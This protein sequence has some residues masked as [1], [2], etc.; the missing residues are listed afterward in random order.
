M[1][2]GPAEPPAERRRVRERA[3]LA[4]L[5]LLTCV[6]SIV[7]SL[8]APLV[9]AVAKSYEIELASAQWILSAA[10]LSGALASPLVGRLGGRRRRVTVLVTLAIVT[11]GCL[12]SAASASLDTGFSA[13]AAGRALQGIGMAL[14]PVAIAVARDSIPDPR[15]QP[16]VALLSVTT[17]ACAG[18]GYPITGFVVEHGDLALAYWVGAGMTAATFVL[19]LLVLPQ[20]L[21][22]RE[23]PLDWSG[24]LLLTVA[25]AA[26]LLSIT[27]G[28]V[29]GWTSPAVLVMGPM[30]A[31][32]LIVWVWWT[33]R[34]PHPI[35]DLRLAVRPGLLAPHLTALVAGAGMYFFL[36][37]AMIA[38]QTQGADGWGLGQ[39]VAVASSLVAPYS[40]ASV[41]GS[42][43]ALVIGRS[44]PRALLPLGC[45][46]FLSATL[47]LAFAHQHLWQ[48]LLAMTLGGLGGGFTF[49]SLPLLL[50]PRVPASETG[51]TLAVNQL[52]RFNGMAVGSAVCVVLMSALSSGP[53]PEE[54]G[55]RNALLA[56]SGVWVLVVICLLTPWRGSRGSRGNRGASV[57]RQQAEVV[58]GPG[59]DG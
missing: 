15:M 24:A 44:A 58:L 39:S 10:L 47:L 55:F 27:Q 26:M 59:A 42:R 19:C 21:G 18:L 9:P 40:I 37:L 25:M 20:G 4:T 30:G 28:E 16:A 1:S 7:S 32:G 57:P 3:L 35:I 38:V 54:E 29:W 34:R 5:A 31:I 11:S 41:L 17:V 50:I 33:L 51:S 36:S 43:V 56:M 2:S 46:M 49:S 12:L 48:V 45:A 13:M 8:G 23:D 14:T 22:A 53:E 52:L 6:T